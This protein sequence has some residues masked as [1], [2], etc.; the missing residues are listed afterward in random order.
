MEVN[1]ERRKTLSQGILNGCSTDIWK[2]EWH[3]MPG[4][5]NHV[6]RRRDGVAK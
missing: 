5:V 6:D 2:K 3:N 4:N 1:I